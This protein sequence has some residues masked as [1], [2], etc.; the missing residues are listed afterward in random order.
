MLEESLRMGGTKI[1]LNKLV[2]D[3]IDARN[4]DGRMKNEGRAERIRDGLRLQRRERM[5]TRHVYAQAADFSV[6]NHPLA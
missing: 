5:C 4:A 3:W 2:L 6:N 1:E